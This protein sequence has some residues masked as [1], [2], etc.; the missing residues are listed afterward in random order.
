LSKY[1]DFK[2][3][4]IPQIWQFWH[5]FSQKNPLIELHLICFCQQGV[6]IHQ[7]KRTD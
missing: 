1:D 4:Q 7:K 3:K 6:K 2:E 5:I